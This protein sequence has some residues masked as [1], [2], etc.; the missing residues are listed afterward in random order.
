MF[1]AINFR[2]LSRP[3]QL[4]GCQILILNLTSFGRYLAL[5]LHEDLLINFVHFFIS[6]TKLVFLF[7]REMMMIIALTLKLQ[8]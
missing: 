5:F 4:K 2:F 3:V 6:F 8:C 7:S 1:F